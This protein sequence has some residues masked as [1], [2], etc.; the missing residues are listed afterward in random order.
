[1]KLYEVTGSGCGINDMVVAAIVASAESY[2]ANK[3]PQGVYKEMEISP[4]DK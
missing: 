3:K 2:I 4:F 1:M